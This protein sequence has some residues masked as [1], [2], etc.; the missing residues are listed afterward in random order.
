MSSS[1]LATSK[2]PLKTVV[3]VT[4]HAEVHNPKDIVYGRLPRFRLSER[5]KVQA[6]ETARFLSVRPV[7]AIYSSPLLRARQTAEI[8][9]RYHPAIRL[10]VAR[11][12]VEVGSGYEGRPNSIYRQ[13]DFSFYEPLAQE[14]DETLAMVC[15]RM[16]GFLQLI[17]RRHAGETVVTVSHADPITIMRM[18]LLKV[19]LTV[20][21]LH[22]AVY[23]ARSS[24]T[25]VLLN[26]DQPELAYFDVVAEGAA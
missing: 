26:G 23:P 7:A 2:P 1:P 14:G 6:E 18:G 15:E 25:T 13:K 24:V 22:S 11:A 17:A 3:L 5:G 16:L 20:R 4:R 8:L 10:S 12:L 21:N 9:A 19:P